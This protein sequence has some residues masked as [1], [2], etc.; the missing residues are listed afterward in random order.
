MTGKKITGENIRRMN[1]IPDNR[2][3][4]VSREGRV[5]K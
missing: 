3:I 2:M 4:E 1:E 5:I